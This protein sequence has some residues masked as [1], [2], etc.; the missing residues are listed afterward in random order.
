MG[1][2]I[3]DFA[4]V[5]FIIEKLRLTIIMNFHP[6]SKLSLWQQGSTRQG[7]SMDKMWSVTGHIHP[8][9]LSCYMCKAQTSLT[10]C[11]WRDLHTIDMGVGVK[12]TLLITKAP[13]LSV[14]RQHL[15]IAYHRSTHS[16]ALYTFQRWQFTK[17]HV[18]GLW[19]E[20]SIHG[21]DPH[22]TGR[23]PHSQ[24]KQD[25]NLGNVRQQCYSSTLRW[26]CKPRTRQH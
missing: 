4:I 17:L 18:F 11:L 2:W 13:C 20:T 25:S 23:P 5:W 6:F 14:F 24:Q 19:E 7:Y 10:A 12:V 21:E 22:N 1:F 16:N 9:S 15:L 3:F 8:S 26:P